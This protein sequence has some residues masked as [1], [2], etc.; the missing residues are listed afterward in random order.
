MSCQYCNNDNKLYDD[1][2]IFEEITVRNGNVMIAE[3]EG[4]LRCEILQKNGESLTVTLEDV[5]CV[6]TLWVN[7]F[8]IGKPLKYA[9]SIG[10]EEEMIKLM[11]SD[12]QIIF[13]RQITTKN[14]FVSGIKMILALSDV[15]AETVETRERNSNKNIKLTIHIRFW[16]IVAKKVQGWP[17]KL[18]VMMLL[19]LLIPVRH[20][21]L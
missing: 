4:K 12:I 2:A 9:C 3:K 17:K 6:W 7:L 21:Q 1:T 20:V 16:V 8:S 11:K 13:D 19:E 14:S 15:G 10:N 18:W 5:K